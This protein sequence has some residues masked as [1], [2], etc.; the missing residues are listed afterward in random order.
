MSGPNFLDQDFGAESDDDVNFNPAPADESDN[1]GEVELSEKHRG[2]R[3]GGRRSD[4]RSRSPEDT[5]H[6]VDDS[7]TQS[8]GA[9]ADERRQR[10]G[11]TASSGIRKT[12]EMTENGSG[13]A[14]SDAEKLEDEKEPD[15]EGDEDDE[16]DD[17][18]DEEVAVS[19]SVSELINMFLMRSSIYPGSSAKTA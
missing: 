16:D 18:D 13:E 9:K 1:E 8:G 3:E 5:Q 4:T 12:V 15:D 10:K 2:G 19:G 17:E 11:K 14:D 6:D 7:L